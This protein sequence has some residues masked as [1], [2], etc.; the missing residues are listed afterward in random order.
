MEF[1]TGPN[2]GVTQAGPRFTRVLPV[3]SQYHFTHFLKILP[4]TRRIS[5]PYT[6]SNT[7]MD[8]ACMCNTHLGN[9]HLRPS[10]YPPAGEGAL[11]LYNMQ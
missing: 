10:A 2:Q 6:R 1:F 9:S 5:V 4:V 7:Q 3:F 8:V 11:G